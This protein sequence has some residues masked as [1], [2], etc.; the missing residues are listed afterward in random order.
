MTFESILQ[1]TF[2]WIDVRLD[3]QLKTV[4][5]FQDRVKLGGKGLYEARIS[6]LTFQ[7]RVKLCGFENRKTISRSSQVRGKGVIRS[8]N[9]DVDVSRSSQVMWF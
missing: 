9:L 4:K 3:L 2:D 8:S 1:S 5:P 7:D 6:M